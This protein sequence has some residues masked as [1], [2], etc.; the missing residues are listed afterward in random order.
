MAVLVPLYLALTVAL[1]LGSGWIAFSGAMDTLAERARADLSLASSRLLV[2]L[3]RHRDIAVTLAAHPEVTAALMEGR[4]ADRL[5]QRTA[6]RTGALRI[7]IVGP[8]GSEIS[9][10]DGAPRAV[11]RGRVDRA[12]DGALGISQGLGDGGRRAFR[13]AAPVFVGG[14]P[15]GALL[16]EADLGRIEAP[17]RGDPTAVFFTDPGGTVTITN[18]SELLFMSRGAGERPFA[19][20][21]AVDLAGHEVW[22]IAAGRY[23]PTRALHQ[24]RDLASIQMRGEVLLSIA[25]AVRLGLLQGAVAGALALALGALL[26]GATERL[27]LMRRGRDLLE[28]R[29]A[30]RTAQLSR[31][32]EERRAAEAMLRRAQD[33]LVRAG[34][35]SALGQM[36]AGL[37]HE[38]NQPLMAIGSFAENAERFLERGR[39]DAVRENL[40]RISDLARRMGRIIANLRAFA[41]ERPEPVRD[42]DVVE[43]CARVVEMATH[44]ARDQEVALVWEPP[45]GPVTVR[46]GAVRIEQVLMNLVGNAL[47]AMPQG[48]TLTLGV[49]P[50][51]PV[52]LTVR[53]TGPGLDAPDKVFEPFYSTK[54]PGAAKGLGLGLS[55]SYA[56]V[57]SFGGSI[58]AE[59]GAGGALFTVTLPAAEAMAA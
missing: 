33:D 29:V 13:Y 26:L 27:R 35:M 34:K 16:V 31:E 49:V 57:E 39:P 10:S 42:V 54:E 6:D 20:F 41:R 47:D 28:A 59:N 25:P 1:A 3:R 32:V 36:S 5:L 37:G 48:G 43:L 55:I 4:G 52:T 23:V 9:A 58:R 11:P 44:R 53:D 38:L 40:S 45:K 8:E 51:A 46:G 18:R 24:T 12:M 15:A 17:W 7:A 14:A 50:G 22:N 2:E 21:T 56:I 30:E 19:P